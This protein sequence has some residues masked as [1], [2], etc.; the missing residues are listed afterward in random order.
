MNIKKKIWYVYFIYGKMKMRFWE[1]N[2]RYEINEIGFENE[3]NRLDG[4]NIVVNGVTG[5]CLSQKDIKNLEKKLKDY[6]LSESVV[7]ADEKMAD[8]LDIS[9]MLFAAK[10]YELIHN[11]FFIMKKIK[12]KFDK[13]DNAAVVI[14]SARWELKDI[15]SILDEL[16]DN[17]KKIDIVMQYQLPNITGLVELAYDEWGVVLHAYSVRNY[18]GSKKDFVIFLVDKWKDFW[19]KKV[20]FGAA[21][22]VTD[23][24]ESTKQVNNNNVFSGL[25]YK[26]E[27]EIPMDIGTQMAWKKPVLCEKFH[28][29]VI[30]I[31]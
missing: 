26:G 29:S 23:D 8:I 20:P 4:I 28:V 7:L 6:D 16:K 19:I 31:Y 13:S 21:Y 22:V 11:C 1:K 25:I 2:T 9:D 15:F 24:T 30:D 12:Q 17:Y 10:K 14:G 5:A 3:E 18:N 27:K